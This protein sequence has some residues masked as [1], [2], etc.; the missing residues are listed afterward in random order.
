[1]KQLTKSNQIN[2]LL[3]AGTLQSGGTE[4]HFY[5][6]CTHLSRE[7]FVIHVGLEEPVKNDFGPI[8]HDVHLLL[9]NGSYVN[10]ARQL[11]HYT[12]N[13]HIQVIYSCTFETSFPV[14]L[15]WPLLFFRC[16]FYTGVRGR[17]NFPV[18]RKI[19][20]WFISAISTQIICNSAKIKDYVPALFR[21][22]CEVIYNGI[23]PPINPMSK[24]Q[25]REK[26]KLN[27]TTKMVG[28][29]ARLCADKG[30]DV[31]IEAF[32]K[33]FTPDDNIQ[34]V[35]IGD[36]EDKAK[37]M[38]Q[39]SLLNLEKQILLMGNLPNASQYLPA[40]D[41][42]VLPSRN[43]SFPNA[44]LEAMQYGLPCV[45]TNVGGV[46]EI[47]QTAPFGK[48]VEKENISA[49]ALALKEIMNQPPSTMNI[50]SFTLEKNIRSLEQV[51][52]N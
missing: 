49:M 37:L 7:K 28:C 40:F 44:L 29:I 10:K 18:T 25:A 4:K 41:V 51:F 20:E 35:L 42:F 34:L 19:I 31:L 45:A 6:L 39:I 8:P 32:A 33:A 2:L 24:L 17:F 26:L 48:M 22:K 16:T 50:D 46:E 12:R 21:N 13:N 14:L 47:Y 15:G 52:F 38:Q 5:Q 11:Y 23:T 43:E 9:L 30:Q 27:T 3:L 1:M 36:G